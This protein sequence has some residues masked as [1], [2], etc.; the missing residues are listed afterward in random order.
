MES[1]PGQFANSYG[2]AIC[3]RFKSAIAVSG[4]HARDSIGSCSQ[5]LLERCLPS[6][7]FR[8][9]I[10]YSDSTSSPLVNKCRSSNSQCPVARLLGHWREL[11]RLFALL[12]YCVFSMSPGFQLLLMAA[13][14]GPYKRSIAK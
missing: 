9:H 7:F 8:F 3:R 10:R 13:W 14:V 2:V 5:S 12:G 1:R 11:I 6:R 4:N